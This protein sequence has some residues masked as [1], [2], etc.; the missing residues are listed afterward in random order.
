MENKY[1]KFKIL[2]IL[3]SILLI[4]VYIVGLFLLPE[5]IQIHF[6]SSGIS[7]KKASKYLIGVLTL[8]GPIL[9]YIGLYS[10]KNP[11]NLTSLFSNKKEKKNKQMLLSKRFTFVIIPVSIILFIVLE[12]EIILVG[13]NYISKIL[14]SFIPLSLVVIPSL[15][16]YFKS[17]KI[18]FGK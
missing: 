12:I 17:F 4:L 8:F 2:C 11:K 1:L 18:E 10:Y 9:T 5:E 14:N 7:D 3:L 16:F 15:I 6:N 13:L